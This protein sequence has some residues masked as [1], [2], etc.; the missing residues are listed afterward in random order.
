MRI[1]ILFP[2]L[3]LCLPALAQMPSGSGLIFSRERVFI[4]TMFTV[5][6]KKEEK[7][8]KDKEGDSKPDKPTTEERRYYFDTEIRPEESLKQE[9]FH[10]LA[11]MQE[12]RATMVVFKEAQPRSLPLARIYKPVDVLVL[13][14][15]GAIL[16]ILPDITLAT[17]TR[18]INVD[19][20]VKA[21]MFMKN[22]EVSH[23]QIKPKDMA[24]HAIFTRNPTVLQ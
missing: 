2:L 1:F 18:E 11:N 17:Q 5:E 19:M 14:E 3:L 12:G 9:W 13:G 23:L 22:G 7:G 15:D 8:E 10:S 24:T 20:P 4:E 21:F 6:P 16:A